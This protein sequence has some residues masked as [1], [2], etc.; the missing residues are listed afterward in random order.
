MPAGL[1]MLSPSLSQLL[2]VFPCFEAN[3]DNDIISDKVPLLR[4]DFP[5]SSIWPSIP[6]RGHFYCETD[7]LSHPLVSPST[8]QSWLGSPPMWIAIGGGER[9]SDSARVVAQAAARQG[10]MVKWEEYEAM[11]HIW[12][13]LVKRWWQSSTAIKHWAEACQT[14]ASSKR[15]KGTACVIG[16]DGKTRSLDLTALTQINPRK[17]ESLIREE[18]AKMTPWTGPKAKCSL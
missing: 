17:A 10:V 1:A 14:F 13:M 3:A 12:V 6:P 9:C 11:P 5:S 15:E 16:L 18:A 7:M 2:E 8:A 4:P